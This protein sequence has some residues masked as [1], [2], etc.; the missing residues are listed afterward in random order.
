MTKVTR[1]EANRCFACRATSSPSSSQQDQSGRLRGAHL[2]PNLETA[3]RPGERR[4]TMSD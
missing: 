4:T 1:S 3:E 2:Q